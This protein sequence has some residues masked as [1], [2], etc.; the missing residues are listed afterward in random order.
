MGRFLYNAATGK[1]GGAAGLIM[2]R[3]ATGQPVGRPPVVA[4]DMQADRDSWLI[5][6]MIKL[7]HKE[8]TG[9]LFNQPYKLARMVCR[10]TKYKDEP[11]HIRRLAVNY[12]KYL[13]AMVANRNIV[14][15]EKVEGRRVTG[16]IMD[17]R[18]F[19]EQ[20]PRPATGIV[21]G[22]LFIEDDGE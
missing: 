19:S 3:K 15:N 12:E 22:N 4:G 17:E 2:P 1:G 6:K 11:S 10:D 13:K 7:A 8:K 21:I 9:F 16:F 20:P 18:F 5:L 14:K